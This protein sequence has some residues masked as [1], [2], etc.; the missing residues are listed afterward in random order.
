MTSYDMRQT[1][2]AS[3]YESIP[4]M[5]TDDCLNTL[6]RIGEKWTGQGVAMELGCWL[7]ASSV[8]LLKGLNKAGYDKPFYAFDRWKANAQQV[9][10]GWEFVTSIGQ[11]LLPQ[12]RKNIHPYINK[13]A[14]HKGKLPEILETADLSDVRIEMLVLDAPKTEPVYTACIRALHKHWIPGVTI[15]CL[16]DYNFYQRKEG[17]ERERL[18]APVNFMIRNEGCFSSIHQKEGESAAFFRYEKPLKNI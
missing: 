14:H 16:L 15:L 3:K 12:Y 18:L 17:V 6:T 13:L 5:N 8:A 2:I 1:K 11:N 9:R 7:G 10:E 4:R